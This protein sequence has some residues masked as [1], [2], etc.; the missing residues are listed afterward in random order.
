MTTGERI[1]DLRH[2]AGLTQAQLAEITNLA[3]I[4]I[5]Q[6]ESG[7]R[8]PQIEPLRKIALALGIT[9]NDLTADWDTLLAAS[10]PN[11]FWGDGERRLIGVFHHL[12]ALGQAVAVER[13]MELAE[14]PRYQKEKP[15]EEG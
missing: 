14:N 5:R 13:L 11:L 9:V 2:K 15:S 1:R 4:T 10:E 6:Y 8:N 7:A 3:T 12:N